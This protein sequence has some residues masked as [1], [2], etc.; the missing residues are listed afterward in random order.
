[1]DTMMRDFKSAAAANGA[2]NPMPDGASLKPAPTYQTLNIPSTDPVIIP[3]TTPLFSLGWWTQY[4]QSAW[5][6]GLSAAVFTFVF[7]FCLNPPIVQKRN[8]ENDTLT[9]PGPNLW[10]IFILSAIVGLLIAASPW[11]CPHLMR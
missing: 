4:M 1:M 3:P 9:R 6:W 8:T 11:I 5:L 10:T 7:L 2:V